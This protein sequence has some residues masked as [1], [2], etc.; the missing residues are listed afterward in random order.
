MS[1]IDPKRPRLPNPAPVDRWWAPGQRLDEGSVGWQAQG[2]SERHGRHHLPSRQ[3]RPFR[4]RTSTGTRLDSPRPPAFLTC[5]LP[6]LPPPVRQL[7]WLACPPALVLLALPHTKPSQPCGPPSLVVPLTRRECRPCKTC[8]GLASE[9][10]P[11]NPPL[12]TSPANLAWL[13]LGLGSALAHRWWTVQWS[14]QRTRRA[15]L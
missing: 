5:C 7:P 6:S 12:R 14:V 10:S 3:E 4:V 9:P 13:R 1:S 8:T 15:T 2:G 11:E